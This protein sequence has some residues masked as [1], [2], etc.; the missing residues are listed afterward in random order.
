M[1][2][3]RHR[4]FLPLLV[5]L[6]SLALANPGLAQFMPGGSQP[7]ETQ[8][9]P[10]PPSPNDV[11]ELMRLL[12]DPSMVEWLR[13]RGQEADND[14]LAGAEAAENFQQENRPQGRKGTPAPGRSDGQLAK[15]AGCSELPGAILA[16]AIVG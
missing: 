1:L 3:I 7:T 9:E 2:K 8:A 4:L 14:S 13:A 15:P 12:S 6:M 5:V 11:R 10:G 16:A